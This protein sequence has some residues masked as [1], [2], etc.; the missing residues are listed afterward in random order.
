MVVVSK[1]LV[2]QIESLGVNQILKVCE[3]SE[4]S[5]P[6]NKTQQNYHKSNKHETT[7]HRSDRPTHVINACC[8][9]KYERAKHEC[10]YHDE[11]ARRTQRILL[12]DKH[13]TGTL[14]RDS[15]ET[16]LVLLCDKLGPRLLREVAD[17]SIEVLVELNLILDQISHQILCAQHLGNL[18]QLVW[19]TKIRNKVNADSM[20]MLRVSQF[21]RSSYTG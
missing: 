6:Q 10:Q 9:S 12:I 1:H 2:E 19:G 15:C 7:D 4:P 11:H 20:R 3:M 8:S 21:K 14:E 5:V 18:D 16:D 17:Q 13:R